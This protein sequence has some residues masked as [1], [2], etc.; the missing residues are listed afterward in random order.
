MKISN[1][2]CVQFETIGTIFAY[3]ERLFYPD[4]ELYNLSPEEI[5]DLIKTA[6]LDLAG[7]GSINFP[8]N[9]V[10]DL[11]ETALYNFCFDLVGDKKYIPNFYLGIL[12]DYSQ[13]A[14]DDKLD[15][16]SSYMVPQVSPAGLH[17]GPQY[18]GGFQD[19]DGN[20][21]KLI[22]V[23]AGIWKL[24][25]YNEPRITSNTFYQ[26]KYRI[27]D[28]DLIQAIGKLTE[29]GKT[30]LISLLYTPC[31][32]I[33]FGPMHDTRIEDQSYENAIT[34]E[35]YAD[36]YFYV[37]LGQDN[38]ILE[39]AY[40][41]YENVMSESDYVA[42][43]KGEVMSDKILYLSYTSTGEIKE[44]KLVETSF[45]HH[46]NPGRNQNKLSM[47]M[48]DYLAHDFS[49]IKDCG[50]MAIDKS[51][52][53]ILGTRDG[54]VTLGKKTKP[55]FKFFEKLKEGS[56]S[57]LRTTKARRIV[58]DGKELVN[59]NR[60]TLYQN[61]IISPDWIL[62]RAIESE[63][64]KCRITCGKGGS[65]IRKI[66][67]KEESIS[68]TKYFKSGTKLILKPIESTGYKFS[69]VSPKADLVNNGYYTYNSIPDSILFSFNHEIYI[70]RVHIVCNKD[71]YRANGTK[72]DF[73]TNTYSTSFKER[74]IKLYLGD[75]VSG[76]EEYIQGKVI[77]VDETSEISFTIDLGDYYVP[78]SFEK[79]ELF[80]A[81]LSDLEITTGNFAD[82]NIEI[83]VI[84]PE[85]SLFGDVNFG[86]TRHFTTDFNGVAKIEFYSEDPLWDDTWQAINHI[87]IQ[88]GSDD[89]VNPT[90]E[91]GVYNPG[92]GDGFRYLT[93]SQIRTNVEINIWTE[94]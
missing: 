6:E 61:P 14:L 2:N 27:I 16:F 70:F 15:I 87:L 57:S 26:D 82:Y 24:E 37:S 22:K 30:P 54:S 51:S 36:R 23:P 69:S 62:N 89:P 93:L 52:G 50:N 66:G 41:E 59:G 21:V 32:K 60:E 65:I 80:K 63:Y 46:K 34:N 7:L 91:S 56:V 45:N 43:Y 33:Y 42:S 76:F 58:M 12:D 72:V 90:I 17:V 35:I 77:S 85:V 18:F 9:Q 79:G 38:I 75:P 25:I 20:I 48:D 47:R 40:N 10:S 81:K 28:S 92:K 49:P 44:I 94:E 5:E 84:K 39:K 11:S 67:S 88:R 73:D 86:K 53:L 64:K 13:E 19:K 78:V 68:G 29:E 71:F 74:G 4:T 1:T 8:S 55:G 31:L 83:A 3:Q